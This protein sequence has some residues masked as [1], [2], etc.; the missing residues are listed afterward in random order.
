MWQ[1]LQ[2]RSGKRGDGAKTDR[3]DVV[4]D[5]GRDSLDIER[6]GV[7]E[8][9]TCRGEKIAQGGL[10]VVAPRQIEIQRW[11]GAGP[12][13]ELQRDSALEDSVIG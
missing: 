6:E 13:P 9:V 4:F 2:H 7:S 10:L 11:A 8:V 1:P 5:L 3:C 12:E